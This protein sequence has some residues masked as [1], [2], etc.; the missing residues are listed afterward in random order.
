MNLNEKIKQYKAFINNKFDF[1][2]SIKCDDC[3]FNND[4]LCDKDKFEN[5][6]TFNYAK[7]KLLQIRE[8]KLKNII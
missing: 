1:C 3:V 2:F 4:S 6:Y 8:K 5:N 7:I